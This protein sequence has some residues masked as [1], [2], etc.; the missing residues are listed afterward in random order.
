VLDLLENVN[1]FLPVHDPQPTES[2]AG[3]PPGTDP[4]QARSDESRSFASL[5]MTRVRV[6]LAHP[7]RHIQ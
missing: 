5:R 6:T 4:S 2:L 3:A 1:A 7:Q